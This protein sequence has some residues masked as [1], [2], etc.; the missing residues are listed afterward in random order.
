M[1][2]IARIFLYLSDI[3]MAS[4]MEIYTLYDRGIEV[5]GAERVVIPKIPENIFAF[6]P[7]LYILRSHF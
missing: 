1:A 7:N 6:S 4:I 3:C 2:P 5:S